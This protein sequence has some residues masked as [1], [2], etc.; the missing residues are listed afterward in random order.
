M[1]EKC[2]DSER[3]KSLYEQVIAAGSEDR[4]RAQASLGKLLAKEGDIERAKALFQ[5]ALDSDDPEVVGVSAVGLGQIMEGEGKYRRARELYQQAMESGCEPWTKLAKM[6][7][8][9]LLDQ[10]E[11]QATIDRL[12]DQFARFTDREPDLLISLGESLIRESNAKA[13]KIVLTR[14]ADS[15][16]QNVARQARD[17]LEELAR[18]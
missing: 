2:G 12:L 16:D 1:A 7:L 3:A 17:L 14:A 6:F 5:D 4:S 10:H 11:L 18:Q 13:A 8:E 15:S 9:I